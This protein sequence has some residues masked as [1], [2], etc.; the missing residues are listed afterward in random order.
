MNNKKTKW[1][2]I[3]AALLLAAVSATTIIVAG[4]LN[5]F[6]RNAEGA[7]EISPE[8]WETPEDL[9]PEKENEI[10]EPETEAEP[11]SETSSKPEGTSSQNGNSASSDKNS[12][13]S[14]SSSKKPGNK[15]TKTSRFEVTAQHNTVW[16]TETEVEIF[17][18]SYKNGEGEVTVQSFNGEK[19]VAPGTENSYTFKLQNSGGTLLYY[20]LDIDAYITPGDYMFPI[21]TRLSRYDGRWIVGGPKDWVDVDALDKAADI[22]ALFQGRYCYYTLD[23]C[24]PFEGNDELDT[25]LGN[26]AENEDITI[27]IVIT[28]RAFTPGEGAEGE[29]EGNWGE[30]N[31]GL[32]NPNTGDESILSLW[33]ALAF[34]AS[35]LLVIIIIFRIREEKRSKTEAPE[36]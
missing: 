22:G 29:F 20:V 30:E 26:L 17:K 9:S 11:E 28:T 18:A 10:T 33:I 1:L 8:S 19:V 3:I 15:N 12:S 23:W 7:I 16:K 13:G 34:G 35:F 6:N 25:Y 14:S 24:W 2:L 5:N 27:T 36:N 31:E 32:V 21:E 4:V